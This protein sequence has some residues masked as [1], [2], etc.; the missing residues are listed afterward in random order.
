MELFKINIYTEKKSEDRYHFNFLCGV[1][2]FKAVGDVALCSV[3]GFA[4][5]KRVG[6]NSLLLGVNW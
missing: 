1:F 4:V 2:S 6:D 3:M 5:F